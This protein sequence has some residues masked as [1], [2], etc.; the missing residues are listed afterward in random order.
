MVI[1]VQER[2]G[3]SGQG[4]QDYHFSF[5]KLERPLASSIIDLN[6]K[7]ELW[8]EK[9]LPV[10]DRFSLLEFSR[11]IQWVTVVDLQPDVN[12]NYDPFKVKVIFEG[13]KIGDTFGGDVSGQTAASLETKFYERW[14]SIYGSCLMSKRPRFARSY[15]YGMDREHV[16]FEIGLFPFSDDGEFVTQILSIVHRLKS[17]S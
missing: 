7:Y 14:A 1:S 8:R 11:Y 16:K 4:D 15:V 9:G 2:T 10:Y 5:E 12:G 3:D 13:N 17:E 6:S